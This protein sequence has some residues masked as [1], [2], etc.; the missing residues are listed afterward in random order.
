MADEIASKPCTKIKRVIERGERSQV[1]NE[2]K[3]VEIQI[4]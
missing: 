4:R 2:I 1:S 3:P